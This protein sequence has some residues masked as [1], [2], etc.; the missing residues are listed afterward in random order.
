LDLQRLVVGACGALGSDYD[1]IAAAIRS[2][3]RALLTMSRSYSTR[4]VGR[5]S[6]ANAEPRAW[7]EQLDGTS[8]GSSTGPT[9]ETASAA[10]ASNGHRVST[11]L[12]K[13][14]D[15]LRND[16]QSRPS[17]G[18]LIMQPRDRRIS[19]ARLKRDDHWSRSGACSFGCRPV[20]LPEMF[21]PIARAMPGF[22]VGSGS[23]VQQIRVE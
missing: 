21:H 13:S 17:T 7:L 9:P 1:A 20:E 15:P 5:H 14:A 11:W 23:V 12:E 4:I 3:L 8:P 16:F 19:Q 10:P 18:V 6:R 22:G 2:E